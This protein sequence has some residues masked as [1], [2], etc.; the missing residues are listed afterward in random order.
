[1][2]AKLLWRGERLSRLSLGTAQLGTDYGIANTGGKP[3]LDLARQ[4]VRTALA[5][6]IDFFDTAQGYG[7][8][9]EAL[10]AGLS[11]GRQGAEALVI[12][13]IAPAVADDPERAA[14]LIKE[15]LAKVKITSF[16]AVL[17]HS[18]GS[19]SDWKARGLPTFEYLKKLGLTRHVG[20]SIYTEEEMEFALGAPEIDLIQ[21]PFNVFDQ[22]ASV[23]GWF[24]RAE[25]A[26][27][28]LI[29]RSIFL[30]GLLLL[31][32]DALPESMAFAR[33]PLSL[34]REACRRAGLSPKE[35][36]LG[37]ALT[38]AKGAAVV[39]GAETPEQVTE[40]AGLAASWIGREFP[41]ADIAGLAAA[42]E[43]RLINPSLWPGVDG[44]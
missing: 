5:E 40:I 27:K 16:F 24:D 8:S 39:F 15:S 7:G 1:M 37:W 20:V 19:L 9:E 31:D 34:W 22:R 2:P 42:G 23:N 30:Q 38:Q 43:P 25:A 36:S 13:K 12:T 18:R 28:L 33:H 14:A 35:A 29:V 32:P 41:A 10:G 17:L 44:E 26:G 6:G 11:D 3:D 21:L 4:I